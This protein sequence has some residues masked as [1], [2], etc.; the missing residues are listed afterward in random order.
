MGKTN[1]IHTDLCVLEFSSKQLYPVTKLC[2][3]LL[4]C[5][6]TFHFCYPVQLD[7]FLWTA[8]HK[9]NFR[10][11]N[12]VSNQTRK[13]SYHFYYELNHNSGV[14]WFGQS[15]LFFVDSFHQ[16]INTEPQL[17]GYAL[18]KNIG[19]WSLHPTCATVRFRLCCVFSIQNLYCLILFFLYTPWMRG[20]VHRVP[21]SRARNDYN[22]C[23]NW[24]T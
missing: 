14:D 7:Y 18:G 21:N 9:L 11:I 3:S 8:S 17:F 4:V 6:Q 1:Q 16:P 5:V 23:R 20:P 15:A 22:N 24:E 12:R 10:L 13:N 19:M 2:H